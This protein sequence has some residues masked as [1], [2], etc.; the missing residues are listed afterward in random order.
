[1]TYI[2]CGVHGRN[3]PASPVSKSRRTLRCK[4]CHAAQEKA[5]R[6]AH[7]DRYREYVRRYR[8]RM[9]RA[10]ERLSARG[11]SQA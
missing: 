3:Q 8:E 2:D 6:D 7:G 9:K 4:A 10:S 5:Y 1:M 11:V